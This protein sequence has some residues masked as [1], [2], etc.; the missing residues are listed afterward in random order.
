ML[1]K[2]DQRRFE[3]IARHLRVTDPEFVARVGDQA[4][5]RRSRLLV[6]L[7]I[8]LWAAVPPLVVV[9]GWFAAMLSTAALVGAATLLQRAHRRF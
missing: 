2:E 3:Q 4:W 5:V 6:F 1:S 7:S 9:G 8:L